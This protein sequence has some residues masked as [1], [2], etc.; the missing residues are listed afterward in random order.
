[1]FEATTIVEKNR[2]FSANPE[3]CCSPKRDCIVCT[4]ST[5]AQ[6]WRPLTAAV[7]LWRKLPI[8]QSCAAPLC[9]TINASERK[10]KHCQRHNG[11][12]GWVHLN[13]VTSLAHITS[14][15]P[16]LDQISSA[17]FDKESTSKSQPNI[18][19]KTKLK[20]QNI[21]QNLASVFRP[22]LN[23]INVVNK[24]WPQI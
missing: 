18:S 3:M 1:M 17:I 15:Y 4:A 7:C 16:N 24:T 23:F 8:P 2:F 19:I 5:Y 9:C 6:Y 22:R 20:I 10:Y 11:P 21:D 12:E 14:S 13:E